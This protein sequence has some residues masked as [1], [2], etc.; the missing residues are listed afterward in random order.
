M[1]A[2]RYTL[3]ASLV[4]AGT[5]TQVAHA[6]AFELYELGTPI[7]G[8]A[9]VGQAVTLDASAAYFNPAAMS[10]TPS[11]QLMLGSQAMIPDINFKNSS[12]N[13]ISGKSTG[14]IGTLT[15]G[16]DLFLS[17]HYSPCMQFGLSVTS[18]YG[19][20][21]TYNDGWPGR[22]VIQRA[23]FYTINVNPSFAYRF[24]QWLSIGAGASVEYMNLKQAT[25]LPIKDQVDGQ[26]DLRVDN[27]SAG[28]NFGVMIQPSETT[29]LGLAYRSQIVHNLDGDI[30]F[31]RLTTT[32]ST[33]VKM[34]M[35]QNIIASLSQRITN[36]ITLLAEA[37][38]ANWASMQ[39]T[40]I[41]VRGFTATIPRHWDDT[42]RA[43]LGGEVTVSPAIKLLAGVSYD[44][45]PTSTSHRLPDL[46]MDRQI[47]VGLGLLYSITKPVTL[48]LSYE[49]FNLGEADINNTSFNGVL[50]GHY[51]RNYLN[52]VQA[53]LNVEV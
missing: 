27:T 25:A 2:F 48:G 3:L 36:N 14:N 53:S 20:S 30:T 12:N 15:P 52:T 31:L 19:G 50:A 24:N 34:V 8:T 42:Y 35:P 11:T 1:K 18:P 13:T 49:Y 47:R 28:V 29:R 51:S 33:S 40:I 45:S 39:N 41:N 5:L 16:M 44:S 38:W 46:P 32:P 23:L 26:V 9:A 7:L 37:G 4:T 43:G 6:A 21:L 10:F 17:Y 22:Y